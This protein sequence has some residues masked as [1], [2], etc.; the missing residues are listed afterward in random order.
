[1]SSNKL[2]LSPAFEEIVCTSCTNEDMDLA[3]Q[4]SRQF[5][6]AEDTSNKTG[7][8]SGSSQSS[9]LSNG[10]LT[11]PQGRVRKFRI[12]AGGKVSNT[13]THVI[14]GGSSDRKKASQ[15]SA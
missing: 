15:I 6:P 13:T 14:C 4:L 1:M 3:L 10:Q 9:D 2:Y 8:C 7:K 11:K 5:S 12:A